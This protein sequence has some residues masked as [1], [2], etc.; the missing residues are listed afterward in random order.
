[1]PICLI[2]VIMEDRFGFYADLPISCFFWHAS[3]MSAVNWADLITT[4]D[5]IA[6]RTSRQNRDPETW[7]GTETHR[8]LLGQMW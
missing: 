5:L 6:W 4:K 7:N 3:Y 2:S 8:I 1:M